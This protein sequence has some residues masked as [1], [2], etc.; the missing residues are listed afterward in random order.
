M[1]KAIYL[2]LLRSV[3]LEL[4]KGHNYV[5]NSAGRDRDQSPKPPRL[6]LRQLSIRLYAITINRIFFGVYV[7]GGGGGLIHLD[8]DNCSRKWIS[9]TASTFF[10][11]INFWPESQ[12][13]HCF[14]LFLKF[15]F[16]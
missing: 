6:I 10:C 16:V 7:C 5:T 8:K 13:G 2:T 12:S 3:F 9:S 11:P 14:T 4:L 15:Q 1:K